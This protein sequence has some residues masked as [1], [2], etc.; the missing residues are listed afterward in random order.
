M[1]ASL[2]S[3]DP[4]L[5]FA[6]RALAS[7][8]A[9]AGGQFRFTSTL[10]SHSE[11]TR[12]FRRHLQGLSPYPVAPPGTSAHEYGWAFDA[13]TSPWEWQADVGQVW[14]SWGG[15]WGAR[16]DP[17]HFELPGASAAA[18]VAVR[19]PGSEAEKV[20][21]ASLDLVL[22]FLPGIGQ[23][24]LFATVLRLFPGWSESELLDFLSGPAGYII[25]HP[26]SLA[27]RMLKFAVAPFSF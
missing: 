12:L 23:A 15:V 5:A 18:K 22:G 4:G 8:V 19:E 2:D 6:A 27:I 24:E 11:Q 26:E 17:V 13:V 14:Q 1:G 10:R 21:A 3:L 16:G 9:E 7:A 25:R 20:F